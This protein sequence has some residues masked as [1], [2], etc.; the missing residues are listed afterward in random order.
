MTTSRASPT[1]LLLLLLV[2]FLV[3]APTPGRAASSA[4]RASGS[5]GGSSEEAAPSIASS[6]SS[7]TSTSNHT[8]NWAVLVDTSRYWF[9]YRHA[10]NTLSFYRTVKRL[11]IPDSN[12]VLMLADDFACDARNVFA[13]KIFAD[14]SHATDLYGADVEIDYRGYEVTPE[15]VLRVLYGEHPPSTPESKRLRS[16]AGSNV[17]FYLTGHGGDEF[18]KFQD[19]REILSRDVADALSHMHAV[20]RYNEVLFIV[21]TCQAETLANEIRSPRVISIGSSRRG[22]NSFSGGVDRAL[23]LSVIDRFSSA[24]LGF[25]EA[26]VR[27][28]DSDARMDELFRAASKEAIMSTARPRLENYRHRELRDVRVTEFFADADAVRRRGGQSGGEEKR[29]AGP[30]IDVV[31]DEDELRE[32]L[33]RDAV[34]R[35]AHG[36]R[37]WTDVVYGADVG[38]VDDAARTTAGRER[39]SLAEAFNAEDEKM[40]KGRGGAGRV[41]GRRDGIEAFVVAAALAP[42]VLCLL[43]MFLP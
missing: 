2:S 35:N 22:E 21:D 8:N 10:A 25:A 11:G 7:S 38:W 43:H 32:R 30:S 15:N 12:I 4:A 31:V 34:S 19:Q 41:R 20:G 16:D 27:D 14:E 39:R 37:W 36:E 1:R 6:S 23:G 29:A 24:I 13:S 40:S 3:L 28:V 18:L 17:L 42:P 5:S 33:R 9:N 26:R